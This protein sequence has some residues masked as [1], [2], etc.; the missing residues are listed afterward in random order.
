MSLLIYFILVYKDID[1]SFNKSIAKKKC[2]K[3]N[4][5]KLYLNKQVYILRSI[6]FQ[7]L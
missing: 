2:W 6:A 4:A 1:M 3:K 7:C 5:S